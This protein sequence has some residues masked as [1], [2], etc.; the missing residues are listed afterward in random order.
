MRHNAVV[1]RIQQVS[2]SFAGGGVPALR[3]VSLEIHKGEWLV[4]LGSSGSGKTT[5][6]KLINRLVEDFTGGIEVGGQDIARMDPVLLRR[7]IGYVFQG[8]GLFPHWTVEQNVAAV[9]RLLGK[10]PEMQRHRAHELMELM[11]LDPEIY[12]SRYPSQLSGGQRQRVGVARALA[13][14]P[15]C[16]LMDEPFGALD[17]VTRDSLQKRMLELKRALGKTVVFVTHDLFE[18]MTLADRIGVMHEGALAQVGTASELIRSPATPFV[19]ELFQK[20]LLQLKQLE[21]G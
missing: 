9:F 3:D 12:A 15:D 4:L 11:E 18:A 16:L 6:L 13:A 19:K 5:L 7:S 1:I 14:E 17:G 20:P 10:P 8:V 2:K 21:V